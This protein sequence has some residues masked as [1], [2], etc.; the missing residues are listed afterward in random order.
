M[1]TKTS[2]VDEFFRLYGK[3]EGFKSEIKDADEIELG[4]FF[5]EE[6]SIL[7]EST[8]RSPQTIEGKW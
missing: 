5:N 7:P 6:R 3:D 2:L 1:L 8:M 4:K